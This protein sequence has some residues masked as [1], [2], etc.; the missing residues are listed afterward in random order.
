MRPLSPR[1]KPNLAAWI[2]ARMDGEHYGKMVLYKF[3][4]QKLIYGPVQI[5]SRINQDTDISREVSL[6]NQQGSKAEFGT[7]LV[8]PIEE[9][10]IYVQPLYIRATSREDAL[11]ELKRVIVAYEDRIAMER[12][13]ED[14]LDVLFG[15]KAPSTIGTNATPS[16]LSSA[17]EQPILGGWVDRAQRAYD[18]AITRQREGDWAGY[19]QA[20]NQ[21]EAA[22]GALKDGQA[23]PSDPLADVEEADEEATP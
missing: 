5:A 4:K 15:G 16:T 21:L 20:L 1:N 12:T 17:D 18:D 7:M 23:P 11:P 6:W 2:V 13:L 8:L 9:S 19:G 3:P 22:L 10:L 14:S